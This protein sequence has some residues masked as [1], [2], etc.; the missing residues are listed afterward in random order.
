MSDRARFTSRFWGKFQESMGTML[1]FSTT[2]H[3]QTN[4]QLERVIQILEDMLQACVLDF[5][6]QWMDC[7]PYAELTYSNSYQ[8]S[9]GMAPYEALYGRK[10]QVPLHWGW[11]KDGYINRSGRVCIQKMTKK[12]K[13]I[14]ERLKTTQS[15]S[16]SYADNRRRELEFQTGDRVFLRHPRGGK[17]SSKYLRPFPILERVGPV[18]Y[19]LDLPDGLIGIHDVFHISQLKKYN[20]DFEHVLNEEPLQL[21]PGL[22]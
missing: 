6:N 4:G 17:L 22:S 7:L 21:Q 8:A 12:V 16:K 15:R 1:K 13:L 18:A 3:P 9:I 14:R 11:T 20:P 2:A 10:C 5:G 19:Q